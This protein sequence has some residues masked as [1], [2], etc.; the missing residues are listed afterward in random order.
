LCALGGVAAA[1]AR[2]V[3]QHPFD[4]ATMNPVLLIGYGLA[5]T[6]AAL[7]INVRAGARGA[8]A[9]EVLAQGVSDVGL[10][11]G[12]LAFSQPSVAER[13][14]GLLELLVTYAIVWE[15]YVG[16]RRFS[17]Q[18]EDVPG[19]PLSVGSIAGPVLGA[20]EL[21]GV[22][23]SILMAAIGADSRVGGGEFLFESDA[24]DAL[25]AAGLGVGILLWLRRRPPSSRL[26]GRLLRALSVVLILVAVWVW[27]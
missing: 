25:V 12:I 26:A 7:A 4:S 10:A 2:S 22:I 19:D 6:V 24:L 11:L 13:F 16:L 15:I 14:G 3:R 21:L 18:V 23:P 8:T 27:I 9:P 20:W 17:E 5:R 1:D